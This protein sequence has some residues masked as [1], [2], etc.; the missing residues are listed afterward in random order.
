MLN[1]YLGKVNPLLFTNVQVQIFWKRSQETLVKEWGRVTGEGR[2]ANK[3]NTAS[4]HCGQLKLTS[5]AGTLGA[6]AE[7]S[8]QNCCTQGVWEQGCLYPHSL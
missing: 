7:H 3:H 1:L 2:T 4:Y 6:C 8:S 5:A